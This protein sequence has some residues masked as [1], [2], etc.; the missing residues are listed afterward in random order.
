MMLDDEHIRA[1]LSRSERIGPAFKALLLQVLTPHARLNYRRALALLKFEYHY[2]KEQLNEAAKVARTHK[3][4]APK[5]FKALIE[6]LSTSNDE[7][8]IPIS[9]ETQELL[10]EPDYFIN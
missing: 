5:Q 3:I 7:Q 2:A 6:R 4:H 10:R 8:T 1:L 9:P